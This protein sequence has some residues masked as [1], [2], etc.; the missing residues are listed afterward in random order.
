MTHPSLIVLL[1]IAN[2][3]FGVK[4][5]DRYKWKYIDYMWNN[6]QKQE[7]I[8]SDNYDPIK[9]IL[10]DVDEAPDG[11]VFVTILRD[12]GVPASVATIS[13]ER[14]PGG[15]LLSPYPNW[16]WYNDTTDCNNNIISVLR[17][18]IKCNHLFALDFGKKDGLQGDRICP[19]KLLIFN[20]ENDMLVDH[21]TIPSNIADNKNGRGLLA[22]PL[23]YVRDCRRIDNAIVSIFS[24]FTR[25]C[26]IESNFMKPTHPNFTIENESFYLE[27]SIVDLFYAPLAGNRILKMNKHTLRKCSKLNNSEAN[28]LTKIVGILSGQTGPMAS[29]DNVIFF[30]NIPETSIL[31]AD[32]TKKFDPSN[33]VIIAQNS[34][35]LQFP[36]GLKVI[37]HKERKVRKHK[38]GKLL[39]ATNRLQRVFNNNLNLNETNF[40]ILELDIIKIKKTKCF[41]SNYHGHKPEHNTLSS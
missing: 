39:I 15:P 38:E 14:G 31:C 9:N 13:N 17:I 28:R 25:F 30:S 16:S 10:F 18:S 36:G 35:K 37:R 11:R 26:R 4:L 40:R 23:A 8:K 41:D 7:V 12:K 19:P 2:K 1:V 22:T 32:T 24:D 3:S 29:Q 33:S 21:V 6:L 34:K 27:D 5:E 20:L